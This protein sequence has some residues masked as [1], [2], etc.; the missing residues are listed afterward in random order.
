MLK[1]ALATSFFNFDRTKLMKLYYKPL[2]YWKPLP[3]KQ[4]SISLIKSGG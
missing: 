4:L 1:E 3:S 2:V